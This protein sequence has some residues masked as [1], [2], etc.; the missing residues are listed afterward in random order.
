MQRCPRRR[1][2]VGT[3]V[4]VAL[5]G[6]FEERVGACRCAGVPVC[7]PAADS[8][9]GDGADVVFVGQVIESV[10]PVTR[11]HVEQLIAG[12]ATTEVRLSRSGSNCDIGFSI[13]ERYLV[14]AYRDVKSGVLRTSM[15]SRTKPM[16]DPRASADVAYFDALRA[17]RRTEGWLSGVVEER[18]SDNSRGPD[19][20]VRGW[21]ARPL[22]RIRVT[23]SSPVGESH[24]AVT[25]ANGRYVF[26]GLAPMNWRLVA[27][28][29]RP[30]APHDGLVASHYSGAS[31]T[32]LW[33]RNASC[34][35]ADVDARVD[36]VVSGVLL[37]EDGRPAPGITVEL[38]NIEAIESDP[39]AAPAAKGVTNERG[40]FEFRPLPAGRYVMGVQLLKSHKTNVLDRRRY[41]PGVRE[42]DQA[43]VITL[44]RGERIQLEAFRLPPLPSERRITIVL[45]APSREIAAATSI[46]LLGP[47]KQQPLDLTDGSTALTLR[48]GSE[49]RVQVSAPQGYT[50]EFEKSDD[51]YRR[52]LEGFIGH[53]DTDRTIEVQIRPR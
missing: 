16:S 51:P 7:F 30:L 31:P 33:L 32:V 8:P 5:I 36:G 27:D 35:E 50:F 25:D 40:R 19:G 45:R 20:R 37:G 34:A 3:F 2:A 49:Y 17:G 46:F 24:S 10:D 39:F 42:Q 6:A 41:H 43:T 53:D 14:Y 22:A 23:V 26:T 13:G 28:L 29:P 12:E 18:H 21:I 52:G 47:T 9:L 44:A 11:F 1:I 48:Y 4:C 38:S 15:C